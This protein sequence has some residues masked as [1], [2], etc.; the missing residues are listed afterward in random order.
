MRGEWGE[1]GIGVEVVEGRGDIF[2]GICVMAPVWF[3]AIR[4]MRQSNLRK[5]P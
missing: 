5:H 1:G 3:S 4:F 2:F